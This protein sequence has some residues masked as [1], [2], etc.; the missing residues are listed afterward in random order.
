MIIYKTTNL[1]N[2]KIYIGQDSR[3]IPS[4][5]GSG[6]AIVNAIKKYGKKNFKKEILKECF[7]KKE[8]DK[9]E[10]EFIKLYD[11]TNRKIG[12]NISLGGGG[13]L[14]LKLSK[15]HKSLISKANKEKIVSKETR[16]KIS[17]SHT[18]KKRTELHKKNVSLNHS[19]V[20]GKNNPMYGK[21]HTKE[22]KNRISKLNKGR[23]RTEEVLE[24][25]RIRSTGSENSNAKLTEKDVIKI[26]NLYIKKEKTIKEL[27][28]IYNV[29][30]P[31][32]NKI[33]KKI[34]WKH[35]F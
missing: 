20:S 28:E 3:N 33:V 25:F 12:Y 7:S 34:T 21:T 32:I 11:S 23:K 19:D 24:K 9:L 5:I 29:N 8:M 35:L 27:S 2:G 31:C 30:P 22:A 16:E 6:H 4:Y 26:R 17:K 13:S 1:I 10:I 14:G 15:E 18:G